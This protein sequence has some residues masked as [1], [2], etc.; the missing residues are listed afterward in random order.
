VDGRDKPGHDDWRE[1]SGGDG[2]MP[3]ILGLKQVHVEPTAGLI[4]YYCS[5]LLSQRRDGAYSGHG[6]KKAARTRTEEFRTGLGR[7]GLDVDQPSLTET[8]QV[9]N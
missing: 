7:L 6:H 2:F 9:L 8:I 3:A 5:P 4:R 1:V